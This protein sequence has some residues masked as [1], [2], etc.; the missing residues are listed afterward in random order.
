MEKG[1]PKWVKKTS[2]PIIHSAIDPKEI[3]KSSHMAWKA[4]W[5]DRFWG[6]PERTEVSVAMKE[7]IQMG[8][9]LIILL[10]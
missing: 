10:V 9:W 1:L 5:E 7:Y 3:S 2:R 4:L 6:P 8:P